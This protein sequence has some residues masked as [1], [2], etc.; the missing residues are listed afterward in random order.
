[1]L[2]LFD[3]NLRTI[4]GLVDRVSSNAITKEDKGL[5]SQVKDVSYLIRG[6]SS[7]N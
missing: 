1:M 6:L 5:L 3:Q 4:K 2:E 7:W